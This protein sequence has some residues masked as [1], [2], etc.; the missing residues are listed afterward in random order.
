[1]VAPPRPTPKQTRVRISKSGQITLP[2]RI[3]AKLG[4]DLGDFVTFSEESDGAFKI[5][6]ARQ[7]SLEEIMAESV[8][9]PQGES[10][11]QEFSEARRYGMVRERYR[12]DEA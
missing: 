3:R 10:R 11:E 7:L 6:P 5:H 4:V 2:A 9:W 1:M 12:E 8:K